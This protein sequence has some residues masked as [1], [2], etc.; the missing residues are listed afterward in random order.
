MRTDQAFKSLQ[1]V[2]AGHA[3]YTNKET[4]DAPAASQYLPFW[5]VYK[6]ST[7]YKKSNLPTPDFSVTVIEFVTSLKPFSD[8]PL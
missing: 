8:D 2:P 3:L 4:D 1:I 7:K 6:P 5:H